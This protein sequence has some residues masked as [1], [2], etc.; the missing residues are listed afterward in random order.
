MQCLGYKIHLSDLQR[1]RVSGEPDLFEEPLASNREFFE[2]LRTKQ[3]LSIASSFEGQVE[4]LSKLLQN[5]WFD[6]YPEIGEMRD[7]LVEMGE[8]P[9]ARLKHVLYLKPTEAHDGINRRIEEKGWFPRAVAECVTGFYN[10]AFPDDAEDARPQ[11]CLTKVTRTHLYRISRE[12]I[13]RIIREHS[14]WSTENSKRIRT[15]VDFDAVQK[16]IQRQFLARMPRLRTRLKDWERVPIR[17][18]ENSLGSHIDEFFRR[19][20]FR[21]LSV[22]DKSGINALFEGR[23]SA[24]KG[25][26]DQLFEWF[27]ILKRA[28]IDTCRANEDDV[29]SDTKIRE[30]DPVWKQGQEPLLDLPLKSVIELFERIE[31]CWYWDWIGKKRGPI[32]EKNSHWQEPKGDWIRDARAVKRVLRLLKLLAVRYLNR[33]EVADVRDKCIGEVMRTEASR[34]GLSLLNGRSVDDLEFK[35]FCERVREAVFSIECK[36]KDVHALIDHLQKKTK[37]N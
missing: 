17:H 29:N 24:P 15:R 12:Q 35:R 7:W 20:P 8:K 4:G 33:S 28:I 22:T 1:S 19:V 2:C 30:L 37:N 23:D 11:M 9:E 3:N 14:S 6:K 31:E 34:I 5:E 16:E 25:M 32:S 13:D 26:D 18:I 10:Q 36:C 21:E 27:Q